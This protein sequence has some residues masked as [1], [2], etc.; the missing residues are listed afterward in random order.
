MEKMRKAGEMEQTKRIEKLG[1]LYVWEG[2]GGVR[3][4]PK[5]P[6][7]SLTKEEKRVDRWEKKK[8]KLGQSYSNDEAEQKVPATKKNG[9]LRI[10]FCCV[11]FLLFFACFPWPELNSPGN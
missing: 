4:E 9:R 8:G 7:Q 3:D 6:A 10:F 5:E 2:E 1:A 11:H